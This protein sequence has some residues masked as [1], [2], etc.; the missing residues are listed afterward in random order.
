MV[1]AVS[2]Y[3]DVILLGSDDHESIFPALTCLINDNKHYMVSVNTSETH[4]LFSK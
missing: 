2:N 1:A 3:S 4:L